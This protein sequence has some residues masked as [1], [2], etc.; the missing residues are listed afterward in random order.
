[1]S[2][3]G[4]KFEVNLANPANY[5]IEG[6]SGTADVSE[7]SLLRYAEYIRSVMAGHE[8]KPCCV[9]IYGGDPLEHLDKLTPFLS[10][11]AELVEYVYITTPALNIHNQRDAL[12]ALWRKLGSKLYIEVQYPF[13]DVDELVDA[14]TY[15]T[16]WYNLYWLLA[17]RLGS[18]VDIRVSARTIS[19]LP[20]VFMALVAL[21]ERM[22]APSPDVKVSLSLNADEY[23]TFDV[24][25]AEASVAEFKS[26]VDMKRDV[27]PRVIFKDPVTWTTSAQPGSLM[28]NCMAVLCAD[29]TLFPGYEVP[30][31]T[32]FGLSAFPIGRISDDF[33]VLAERRALLVSGLPESLPEM[34]ECDALFRSVPWVDADENDADE[35]NAPAVAE[36]CELRDILREVFSE[37]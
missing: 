12:T 4:Y 22:Q 7:E 1:M 37:A 20:G 24:A 35:Y 10:S 17:R 36:A 21:V 16:F 33:D 18:D 28:G 30:T 2:Y 9:S 14:E 6:L 11:L 34:S 23:Q 8:G 29:G 27:V 32:N 13:D 25:A 3:D 19:R 31:M 5:F 15:G 26:Y